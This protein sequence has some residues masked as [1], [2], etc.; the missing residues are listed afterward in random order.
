V[1]V[2]GTVVTAQQQLDALVA[3]QSASRADFARLA[4]LSATSRVA[5]MS[6]AQWYDDQ[7]V[8]SM[9]AAIGRDVAGAQRHTAATT[10]A[11]LA[12][13][14]GLML[15]RRV[16]PAGVVNVTALRGSPN[17]LVYQ[18]LGENYRWQRAQGLDHAEALRRTS[19]RAEVMADTDTTL[20]MRA[21]SRRFMTRRGIAGYRRVIRPEAS[22]G[23]TCG[24]CI[25]AADRIYHK[26]DLLPVHD[27]CSCET[28]PIVG[29]QDPG[30]SL[31]SADLDALYGAAGS[32]HR[33]DL[34]RVRIT[35]H[36]HGELGPVLGIKGQ[37]FRGPADLPAA[38]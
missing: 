3:A 33:K 34:A 4:V 8:A 19:Q 23:G 22:A 25:A 24:L 2:P 27:R 5:A 15:D 9:A 35:T 17:A 20:A 16:A 32:T 38:A 13:M 36:H 29:G 1:A 21:Q 10:D 12:R 6:P 26:A 14:T 37:K 7:A 11:Y 31:N 30:Y 28:A 18:R